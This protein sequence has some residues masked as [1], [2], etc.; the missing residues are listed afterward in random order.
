MELINSLSNKYGGS[1]DVRLELKDKEENIVLKYFQ[2]NP[3]VVVKIVDSIEEKPDISV[4]IEYDALYDF[5]SYMS[6]EQGGD[7]I[8]GPRWVHMSGG[9]GPGKFFGTI[10]AVKKMWGE[11]VTIKPRYALLKLLFNSKSLIGLIGSSNS[12]PIYYQEETVKISGK[13]VEEKW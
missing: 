6:Y 5:I 11:G 7:D 1:F 2:I 3:D 9:S 13:V 10:G 8:K 4:E 12:G